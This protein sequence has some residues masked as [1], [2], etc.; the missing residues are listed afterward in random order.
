M[1]LISDFDEAAPSLP[2]AQLT[3]AAPQ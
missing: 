3:G 1:P 2:V